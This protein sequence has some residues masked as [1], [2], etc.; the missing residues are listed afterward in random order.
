MQNQSVRGA[1]YRDYD[2]TRPAV[3]LGNAA[4]GLSRFYLEISDQSVRIPRVGKAASFN[5]AN[6]ASI[7]MYE[8]FTQRH[9]LIVSQF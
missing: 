7:F 8:A 2:F 3:L 1:P 5:A 6:A 4:E 9:S